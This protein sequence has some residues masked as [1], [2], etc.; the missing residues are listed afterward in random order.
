MSGPVPFDGH[1]IAPETAAFLAD[2]HQLLIGGEWVDG[3]GEM[4]STD[5][6]T[7]LPLATF[8]TGGTHDTWNH[9]HEIRTPT[10]VLA[11]QVM[12][13]LVTSFNVTVKVQDCVLPL[14]SLVSN[15]SWNRFFISV[16]N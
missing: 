3:S 16:W 15:K 12:L 7:G 11:G 10:V 9:L 8:A 6:A 1:A 13:G 4:V 5:P 2:R 14:P